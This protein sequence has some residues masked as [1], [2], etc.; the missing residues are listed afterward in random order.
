[1]GAPATVS[2]GQGLREYPD[3]AAGVAV[4]DRE[5][6]LRIQVQDGVTPRYRVHIVFPG[7][8]DGR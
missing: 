6:V 7:R 5:R 4:G 1:M 2:R 3:D 8:N